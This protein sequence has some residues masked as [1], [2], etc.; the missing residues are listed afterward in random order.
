MTEAEWLA[1]EDPGRM[2][3]WLTGLAE[4]DVQGKVYPP[5]ARP[6]DRKLRL[7]ACACCRQGWDRLTDGRCRRAA[8]V[9]ELYADGEASEV[10]RMEAWALANAACQEA[11]SEGYRFAVMA[12]AALAQRAGF[13]PQA[14]PRE[15]AT[16]AALLRCLVGN[17]WRPAMN[18]LDLTCGCGQ[19]IG[20]VQV[21]DGAGVK[22]RCGVLYLS[23]F[24]QWR[25][26]DVLCLAR[27]AYE[28]RDWASLPVLAD[29]LEE[30][31]CGDEDVLQHLRGPGP[32]ARGCWALDLI[33]G[34]G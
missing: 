1:C 34:K 16:Q 29:A 6:S 3:A 7:F 10:E 20:P 8:E 13:L 19:R 9:A 2:L 12:Q 27:H 14:F 18:T 11:E 23:P 24:Q 21:T 30:A 5:G 32:H 15:P 4:T 31:G 25:T 17:P 26:P 22:C 28:A 33:L